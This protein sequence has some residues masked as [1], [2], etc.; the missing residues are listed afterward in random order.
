MA[1]RTIDID[2]RCDA[3]PAIEEIERLR[4]K[5]G[6]VW[7]IM[8]TARWVVLHTPWIVATVLLAVGVIGGWPWVVVTTFTVTADAVARTG[9]RPGEEEARAGDR[10]D[11]GAGEK[12]RQLA[13]RRFR[14][15][16]DRLRAE[17]ARLEN[18]VAEERELHAEFKDAALQ[19]MAA[20]RKHAT[21]S[22][23]STDPQP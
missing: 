1:E 12:W 21:A 15:E 7:L 2:I 19:Q 20:L 14:L 16:L 11:S 17:M 5:I 10:G 23:A 3:D 6:L 8:A 13:E 4:K 22:E 18:D 9:R